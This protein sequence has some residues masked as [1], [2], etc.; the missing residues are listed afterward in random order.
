M[1]LDG[2]ASDDEVWNSNLSLCVCV[3]RWIW[4]GLVCPL[5]PNVVKASTSQ[6]GLETSGEKQCKKLKAI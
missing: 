3:S 5:I 1:I 4:G 6:L 2:K